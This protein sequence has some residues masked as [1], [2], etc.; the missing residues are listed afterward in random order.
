MSKRTTLVC[1]LTLFLLGSFAFKEKEVGE[2][3]D[4]WPR[5]GQEE[6]APLPEN[7]GTTGI[8]KEVGKKEK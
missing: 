3:F 7:K 8:L 4:R 5:F 6:T 2:D 1:L